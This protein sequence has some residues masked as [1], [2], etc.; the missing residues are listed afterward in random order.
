MTID[1]DGLGLQINN[2]WMGSRVASGTPLDTWVAAVVVY[3][4]PDGTLVYPLNLDQATQMRDRLLV[5]AKTTKPKTAGERYVASKT[6]LGLH[7]KFD[8]ESDGIF[9]ADRNASPSGLIAEA[10]A[11]ISFKTPSLGTIHCNQLTVDD[12]ASFGD[13][14]TKVL[15]GF[16]EPPEASA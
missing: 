1:I 7:F 11:S 12:C 10:V 15:A 6:K 9:L 2:I 16:V 14:L 3:I 4:H 8:E 13:V 5:L